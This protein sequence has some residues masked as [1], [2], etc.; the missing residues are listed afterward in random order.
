VRQTVKSV[1][2]VTLT[3][4]DA[5]Q[6]L[7]GGQAAYQYVA[8]S[9]TALP[10]EV[11][12]TFGECDRRRVIIVAAGEFGVAETAQRVVR[13]FKCSPDP[14]ADLSRSP[15]VVDARDG[16]T[17][18]TDKIELLLSNA[19]LELRL[20]TLL[21][22]APPDKSVAEVITDMAKN[23]GIELQARAGTRKDKLFWR[24]SVVRSGSA[25]PIAVLAW[26]CK[27]RDRVA[28][29]VIGAQGEKSLDPGIELADTG[30]CL[31]DGE[32]MPAYLAGPS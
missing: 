11:N 4:G 7:L 24:G 32:P 8:E 25:V 20:Q 31:S 17:R 18:N 2:G 19:E 12:I 22:P 28:A 13:S 6:T 27:E 3:I 29:I 16:W 21:V 14:T 5:K 23:T 26:R 15:V 1:A 30:R 10:Y 9:D